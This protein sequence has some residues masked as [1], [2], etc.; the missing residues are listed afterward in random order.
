LAAE[1]DNEEKED[2]DEEN[3]G[4]EVEELLNAGR[5]MRQE[6]PMDSLL[7]SMI[8]SLASVREYRLNRER[9]EVVGNVI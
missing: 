9:R 5:Q 1:Y 2:E 3:H 4:Q 7:G 8:A 6:L